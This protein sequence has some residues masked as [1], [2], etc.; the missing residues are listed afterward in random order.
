MSTDPFENTKSAEE[1]NLGGDSQSSYKDRSS[2][3][4]PERAYKDYTPDKKYLQNKYFL[5]GL[6]GF[7]TVVACISVYLILNNIKNI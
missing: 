1:Q 6:T 7:L 2:D 3:K 4:N 5:W